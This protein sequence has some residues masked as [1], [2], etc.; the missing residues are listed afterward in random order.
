M[1]KINVFCFIVFFSVN[2]LHAQ[3]TIEVDLSASFS[4]HGVNGCFAL[5]DESDNEY[6]I[7]NLERSDSGYIPA[8]TFKIP[9]AVIA[10]EEGWVSDTSDIIKWNGQEWPVTSWNQD[11][12]LKTSIK[13]SCVWVYTGFAENT[14]IQT[15]YRYIRDF[16]YGNMDLRGPSNRFWLVGAFR[17][18]AKQQI[19]FLRNFY[20]DSLNVSKRSVDMVKDCLVLEQTENYKFSGKT[21]GGMVSETDYIMWLVGYLEREGRVYFYAMNFR[22]DDFQATAPLRYTITK[23]ILSELG[24]M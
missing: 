16:K 23:S 5:Y 21:G 8:S 6:L 18:S 17:I 20:H 1:A 22:S 2:V 4:E 15:Y 9:H 12:T 11:Q 3:R 19:Q 13:Y 7:Y 10:L 14:G 24:L